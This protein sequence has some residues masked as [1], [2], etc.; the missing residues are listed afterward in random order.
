MANQVQGKIKWADRRDHAARDP[1]RK[2]ELL[3]SSRIAVQR[4]RL[5]VNALGFLRRAHDRLHG[6]I[7]LGA[8][9]GNDLSFLR[10][11]DLAELLIS[12]RHQ[13]RGLSE[14]L[15]TI[16]A[17][18][19]G[20]DLGP[21][22]GK[23]QRAIDVAR[24]GLGHGI[25]HGVV[26]RVQDLDLFRL[27][28]PAS[29]DEILHGYQPPAFCLCLN[30]NPSFSRRDRRGKNSARKPDE[31]KSSGNSLPSPTGPEYSGSCRPNRPGCGE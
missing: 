17:R 27:I 19:L 28:D 14:N 10:R 25:D 29:F 21:F 1:Q 26:K 12:G 31:T 2:A 18:E 11:Y 6:A 15:P 16:V 23:G 4:N 5:A 30:L 20:H 8:P 7:R 9:L 13:I 22:F 24:I 3:G